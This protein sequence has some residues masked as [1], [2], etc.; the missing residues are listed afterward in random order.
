MV[1]EWRS[2]RYLFAQIP[3]FIVSPGLLTLLPMGLMAY[4]GWS[5]SQAVIA[6]LLMQPY[7]LICMPLTRP[8]IKRFGHHATYMALIGVISGSTCLVMLLVPLSGVAAF[9]CLAVIMTCSGFWPFRAYVDARF[10]ESGQ[11]QRMM[12]VKSIMGYFM[13]LWVLPAFAAT[14]DAKAETYFQMVRPNLIVCAACILTFV[15]VYIVIYDMDGVNG[16]ACCVRAMDGIAAKSQRLWDALTGGQSPL[17][18]EIYKKH[19]LEK[20]LGKPWD[21]VEG[22]FQDFQ[23]FRTFCNSLNNTPKEGQELLK[24]LDAALEAAGAGG[25]AAAGDKKK[26]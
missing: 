17:T 12:S 8:V 4:H 25:E 15:T 9:A 10:A 16:I 2:R 20:Y 11:M 6:L 1:G 7:A 14:F 26:A 13:N 5:Q 24:S 19:E 3:E 21:A 18:E 23:Q 22:P